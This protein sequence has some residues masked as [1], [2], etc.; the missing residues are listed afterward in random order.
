[1]KE[2]ILN[3]L[4]NCRIKKDPQNY[5]RVLFL[6]FIHRI[7]HLFDIPENFSIQVIFC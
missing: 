5:M 2:T 7:N 6:R 4:N 1:M 3:Q